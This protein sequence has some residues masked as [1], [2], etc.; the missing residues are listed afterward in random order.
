MIGTLSDGSTLLSYSSRFSLTGMT[1]SFYPAVYQGVSYLGVVANGPGPTQLPPG[2]PLSAALDP[3]DV[4]LAEQTG[5][6]IYAP[7]QVLPGTSISVATHTPRWASSKWSVATTRMRP[8]T[9]QAVTMTQGITWSFLQKVNE[10]EVASRPD[11]ME[12]YLNR[13]KD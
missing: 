8:N 11:D 1:G 5:P 2:A 3:W 7:M 6:I 10:E 13:W 4:P 9:L 12:K